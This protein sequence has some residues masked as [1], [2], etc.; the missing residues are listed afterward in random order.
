MSDSFYYKFRYRGK[1][2]DPK[3]IYDFMAEAEDVCQSN[4]WE[5]HIWDEDWKQSTSISLTTTNQT[6]HFDGH[7]PLKGI[8]F[9]VGESESIWLT[10]MPDGMLQSLMSLADPM[11]LGNDADFPWQ[12]TKTGYDPPEIII[13]MYKFLLYVSE[14]YCSVFE[15]TEEAEYWE[16]QDDARF[17]DWLNA[18]KR[19]R[20][21][22]EQELAALEEDH[23]LTKEASKKKF[24]AIMRKYGRKDGVIGE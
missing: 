5:Y 21:I 22:M 12:R 10:F 17:T 19:N 24:Y 16:H 13:P 2:A 7:A 6:M 1:L 14:K 20:R 4:N 23:S 11:F 15:V 3:K 18:I 8:S 9:S